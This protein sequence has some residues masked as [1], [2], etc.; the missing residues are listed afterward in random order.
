MNEHLLCKSCVFDG[1]DYNNQ[2]TDLDLDN[3][4]ADTKSINDQKVITYFILRYKKK[5][6]RSH[7]QRIEIIIKRAKVCAYD[8]TVALASNTSFKCGNKLHGTVGLTTASMKKTYIKS[9]NQRTALD[10]DIM[11]WHFC[12]SIITE[13]G[14]R[15]LCAL[16]HC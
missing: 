4:L 9:H 6:K 2:N 16:P 3:V 5:R 11:S 10:Y 15:I 8:E 12:L 1:R 14:Y 13:L 7:K